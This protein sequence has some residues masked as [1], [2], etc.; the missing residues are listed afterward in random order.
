MGLTGAISR[1]FLYT[2]HDVQTENQARFLEVLDKRRAETPERGLITGTLSLLYSL[3]NDEL[4]TDNYGLQSQITSACKF[5]F[6][7]FFP[8]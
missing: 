5:F 2:F 6:R 1:A 4:I 8:Q 7:F 3:K